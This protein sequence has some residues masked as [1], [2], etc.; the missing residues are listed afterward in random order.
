MGSSNVP[1][2]NCLSAV[3]DP[4]GLFDRLGIDQVLEREDLIPLPLRQQFAF[5]YHDL[6]QRF[7][8]LI[9]LAGDLRALLVTE[10]RLKQRDDP[11]RVEHHLLGVLFIGG[12]ARYAVLSQR[13]DG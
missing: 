2:V 3:L 4:N 7:S 8:I 5:P 9:T 1:W 11:E 12:Y 13:I 10:L 6:V